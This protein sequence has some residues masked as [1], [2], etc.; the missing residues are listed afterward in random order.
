MNKNELIRKAKL[1]A[2]RLAQ[3]RQDPR[4]VKTM[5]KLKRAGFIDIRNIPET[6]G[7]VFLDDA[8]WAA[9]IE[10]RIHELLP[11]I[12]VKHPKFFTF[13]TLPHDLET[14]VQE[15]KRGKAKSTYQGFEAKDYE[16]WVPS[17]GRQDTYP[18]IM[19]S[20]RLKREDITL[21]EKLQK[22]TG[23][24]KTQIIREAIHSWNQS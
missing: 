24:S 19:K 9:K 8:L 17:I 20:F 21:L 2:K 16:R 18:R 11:A 4:F 10:P 1:K 22:K 7:Q 6:R 3:K 15:I 23:Q 13:Q 5:G 14:V 12:I